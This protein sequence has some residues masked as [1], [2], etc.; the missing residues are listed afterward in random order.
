MTILGVK[1]PQIETL[2]RE[3]LMKSIIRLA[4]AAAMMVMLVLSSSGQDHRDEVISQQHKAV[5]V[6]RF[7]TGA[8]NLSHVEK[9]EVKFAQNPGDIFKMMAVTG[10]E[11][12]RGKAGRKLDWHPGPRRQYVI[13][14]AGHKEIEVAGGVKVEL[15]PGDIE[16]IE[17]THGKGHITR[18]VGTEDDVSL[19]L[20][21]ADKTP[22]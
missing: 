19:W 9:I 14:L 21:I 16:L 10:A 17:D 4:A 8:D 13:D 18:N 22:E 7:Y 2:N 11:L 12:H 20:P 1:L 5:Y 15:G 3:E 6:Y